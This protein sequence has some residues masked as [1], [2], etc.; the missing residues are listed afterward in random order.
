MTIIDSQIHAYQANTPKRPW[1]SVPNWPDHVTSD[2]MVVAMNTTLRGIKRLI[3]TARGQSGSRLA[4]AYRPCGLFTP[5][6]K[7]RCPSRRAQKPQRARGHRRWRSPGV[8]G[9]RESS[10][11]RRRRTALFDHPRIRDRPSPM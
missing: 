9:R 2:E 6:R 8:A 1:H 10:R 11:Y 5:D 3:Y 4:L 7:S